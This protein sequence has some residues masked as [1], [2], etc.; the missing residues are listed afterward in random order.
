MLNLD[1][2]TP[3]LKLGHRYWD[4][5]RA[6]RTMPARAD[7]D[8]AEMVPF[9][10]QVVL[11]DVIAD[12][13]DFRY[14]LMGT[15][16]DSH[17]SRPY[18]GIHL[19]TIPHQKAPSRMWDNFSSVVAARAPIITNV[20]YVGPHKDFLQVRDIIMPLSADGA[21]VDMLFIVVDFI[22]RT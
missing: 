5:K 17:M 21:N 11:V 20:A 10:S 4:S 2:A 9:L 12:P 1:Q 7:L 3:K 6:G 8:P 16:I 22:A 18:T 19:S 15:T 14:R 13:A